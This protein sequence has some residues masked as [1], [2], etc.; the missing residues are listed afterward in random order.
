MEGRS[1]PRAF[2]RREIFLYLG[3]FFMSMRNLTDISKRPS[4]H[5]GPAGEPGGGS[6]TGTSETKR[7]CISGLIFLDPDDIKNQ[8]WGPSGTLARNT[9]PLS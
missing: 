2:D 9:A 5:R 7:K 1:F 8:L 3:T 4:L 6:F